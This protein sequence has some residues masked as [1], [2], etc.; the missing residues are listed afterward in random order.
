MSPDRA[1]P[2][3]ISDIESERKYLLRFARK[4]LSDAHAAEDAV[5]DTLLV[6]WTSV[7][8][9]GGFMGRSSVRTWLTAILHHKLMDAYRRNA[10]EARVRVVNAEADTGAATAQAAETY[11]PV[12][13]L[14]QK[15]LSAMLHAAIGEL[16][17]RQR[18]VFLLYQMQGCSGEEVAKLVG[19]SCNNVW[20]T[21]HRARHALRAQL[22]NVGAQRSVDQQRTKMNMA[23]AFSHA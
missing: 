4:R 11:D 7:G 13:Q 16:P 6:A 1:T 15:Q 12:C 17:A 22:Q 14:E 9:A 21:L 3:W 2:T 19:V 23:N 5:Q 8:C 10:T 18:D 20:V